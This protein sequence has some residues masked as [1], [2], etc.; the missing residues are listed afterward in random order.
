MV[1]CAQGYHNLQALGHE[2]L[3]PAFVQS[4]ALGEDGKIISEPDDFEA[5]GWSTT[6]G[7]YVTN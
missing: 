1:P 4:T 7:M 2:T 3:L 6:V 5:T